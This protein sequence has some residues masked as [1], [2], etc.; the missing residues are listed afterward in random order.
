MAVGSHGPLFFHPI[1]LSLSLS[2]SF[3][4][5]ALQKGAAATGGVAATRNK[6]LCQW[7]SGRLL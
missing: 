4:R 6:A 3:S 5:S 1:S 2:L 7:L